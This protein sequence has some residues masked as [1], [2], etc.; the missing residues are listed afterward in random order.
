MTV[1][2][3]A[4]NFLFMIGIPIV[5]ARKIAAQYLVGWGLFGM[6]AVTFILSQVGHIPFNWYVLQ[7]PGW[8][9]ASN[10]V[11]Y[12]LF[13]GLSAGGFEGVARYLTFRFWAK[14]ARSWPQG[15]MVGMGHGGIESILIGI[16]GLINFVILLGLREGYFQGILATVPTEQLPLVDQQI[17]VLFGVPAPLAVYGAL[18]RVFAIMLHLSASLLV[19]QALVRQQL[20]WLVAGILWH[21]MTD[22]LLVYVA[23]LWGGVMA[24]LVLGVMS[25]GSLGIIFG[26]RTPEPVEAELPPLP[27]L[28]PLTPIDISGESLD[29]S[30]Y[31]G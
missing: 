18:E 30:K 20:R 24:E 16:L 6:G 28:I 14:E 11:L 19:M 5:L 15:L 31:S 13:L 8:V 4:L 17:D 10:L 27:E 2:L 3:L 1:A 7:Q 21:A 12:S 26:L 23:S 25:F 22:G 9:D 29:R